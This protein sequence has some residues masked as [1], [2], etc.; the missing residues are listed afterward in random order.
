MFISPGEVSFNA[1]YNNAS[2]V[3]FEINMLND[4]NKISDAAL[5]FTLVKPKLLQSSLI[6][7]PKLLANFRK[8]L[9]NEAVRNADDFKVFLRQLNNEVRNEVCRIRCYNYNVNI[10]ADEPKAKF[11]IKKFQMVKTVV[12]LHC[13][14]YL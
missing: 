12:R 4:G 9:I 3:T 8:W 14:F 6:W 2:S 7:K 11:K 5:T 1:K 13:Y 10:K